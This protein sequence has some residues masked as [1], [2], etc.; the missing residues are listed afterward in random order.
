MEYTAI[1]ETKE[2]N[3]FECPQSFVV[4]LKFDL[5]PTHECPDGERAYPS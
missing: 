4:H 5:L 2:K 3:D 1:I